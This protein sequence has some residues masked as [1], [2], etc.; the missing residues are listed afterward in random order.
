MKMKKI[1][2][3]LLA[4][5]LLACACVGASAAADTSTIVQG[6]KYTMTGVATGSPGSVQ[7]YLFGPNYFKTGTASV[8]DG[9][10]EI[11]FS[12][13]DTEAMGAGQ[14]YLVVQHPMYDK[15]FNVGPVRNGSGYVIKVN[16]QGSYTDPSAT[17]LFNTN[18]RQSANAVQALTD[19]I[20]SENIDDVLTT[21]TL[22]VAL[23]TSTASAPSSVTVYEGDLYPVSGT[24]TGHV[25]D[26]VTVEF[27]AAGF[28]P[29]SKEDP[30]NAGLSKTVSTRIGQSGDW[31]VYID[32]TGL[33][34][35]T[36]TITVS[37]GS[38]SPQTLPYTVHVLER[39]ATPVQ[40][41]E[42]SP[43]S[44]TPAGTTTPASAGFGI[45]ALLGLG[46]ALLLKRR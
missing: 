10:Y 6:E 12:K 18:D 4:V 32:T 34:P 23:E 42:P 8:V 33:V 5:S 26:M 25:N 22:A 43:V 46:G 11:S 38:L 9:T 16:N 44:P 45:L 37:V 41:S 20:R 39:Q 40:T 36:Y 27:S 28:S 13:A 21:T 3:A 31:I 17:D 7:W 30:Q 19:A 29:T 14:Y 1:F 15:V 35:G 24:T 2:L